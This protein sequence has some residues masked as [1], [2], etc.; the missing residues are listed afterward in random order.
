M[1]KLYAMDLPLG[2]ALRERENDSLLILSINGAQA[3]NSI[4]FGSDY[5]CSDI[6]IMSP[7]IADVAVEV[8]GLGKIT[9]DIG[10]G[11]AFYALVKDSSLGVDIRK[12]SVR[13]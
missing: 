3:V 12:T 13:Q 10:Y 1:E 11:G 9:V 8:P 4:L 7:C 6:M 2:R 5:S